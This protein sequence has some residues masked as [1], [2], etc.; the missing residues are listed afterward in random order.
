MLCQNRIAI[1]KLV[2][3]YCMMEKGHTGK[4]EP[5]ILKY[6]LQQGF[7]CTKVNGCV[8]PSNHIGECKLPRRQE[9]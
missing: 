4:C 1:S 7:R 6:M 8:Y 5:P 3:T 2:E 9:P